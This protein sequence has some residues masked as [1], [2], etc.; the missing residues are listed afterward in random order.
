MNSHHLLDICVRELF[1]GL[2]TSQRNEKVMQ[3]AGLKF[4]VFIYS[5]AVAKRQCLHATYLTRVTDM[6]ATMNVTYE[7]PSHQALQ[8]LC[9]MKPFQLSRLSLIPCLLMEKRNLKWQDARYINIPCN[10]TFTPNVLQLDAVGNVNLT[11]WTIRQ[12]GTQ[13]S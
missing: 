3:I 12:A 5:S 11:Q 2:T 1:D 13:A 9:D 6:M 8:L 10:C 4:E 7:H